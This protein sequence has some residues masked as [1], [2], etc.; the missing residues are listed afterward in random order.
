MVQGK[1]K[2]VHS[3]DRAEATVEIFTEQCKHDLNLPVK[4]TPT[5]NQFGMRKRSLVQL[6][7]M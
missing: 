6:G 2:H 3:M 4:T 5:R 1:H 7:I